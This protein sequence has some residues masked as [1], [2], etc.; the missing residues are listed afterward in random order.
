MLTLKGRALI[1]AMAAAIEE[2]SPPQNADAIEVYPFH[3]DEHGCAHNLT[4][5]AV[6][7]DAQWAVAWHDCVNGGTHDIA[8]FASCEAAEFFGLQ[9]A[10]EWGLDYGLLFVREATC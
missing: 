4:A 7:A 2:W 10:E 1:A 8:N 5:Q 6:G 9:L 3:V